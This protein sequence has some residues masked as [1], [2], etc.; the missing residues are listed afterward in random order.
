MMALLD[1]SSSRAKRAVVVG[2]S[3]AGLTAALELRRRLDPHHEVVVLDPHA[4]FT[5]IPSLIWLPLRLREPGEITFAL[6]PVY[7]RKGIRFLNQAAIR[8]DLDSRTVFTARAEEIGYDRLLL[9]TGRAWRS[10]GSAVWGRTAATR[11]R[12]ATS[13]TRS[14]RGTNGSGSSL[15]PGQW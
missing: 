5:F 15:T 4:N 6:A 2:S 3:F 8:L 13:S 12:C 14:R 11:R 9:A 1:G 10:T 7:Q